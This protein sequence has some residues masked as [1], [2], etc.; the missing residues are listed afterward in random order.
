MNL[1]DLLFHV[2]PNG[3]EE[4]SLVEEFMDSDLR[5]VC[6]EKMPLSEVQVAVIL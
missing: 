5:R 6:K 3:V 1:K 4:V 2:G